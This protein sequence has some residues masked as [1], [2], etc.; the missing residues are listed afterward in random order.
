LL[1]PLANLERSCIKGG[2]G[3][4]PEVIL[5][6][7]C[8]LCDAPIEEEEDELDQGDSLICEQCGVNLV[9]ASLDPIELEEE[10]E[11]LE[12]LEEEEDEDDPWR[13]TRVH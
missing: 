3:I 4:Q 9:V 5:M 7:L 11:D 2:A 13:L 8:P 1:K 6:L 12:D 10:V